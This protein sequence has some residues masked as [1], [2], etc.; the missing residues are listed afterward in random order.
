MLL[1]LERLV[2]AKAKRP[3][4]DGFTLSELMIAIAIL[5]ILSAI[6]I[7]NFIS[8]IEKGRVAKA[9]TEIKMLERTLLYIEQDEEE[10][11]DSLDDIGY[12]DLEDPWGT[13]YQYLRIRGADPAP[14]RG[15]LRKDRFMVPVNTDFDLYS[16][17][18]DGSTLTPFTAPVSFDDIV[19]C[20]DGGYIGFASDY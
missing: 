6:A 17:G 8:Y 18:R 7:P 16:N 9:I 14:T 4:Q 12:G 2:P 11:P 19:R 10:L 15:Q 13:P 3:N 20:N 1:I 5:G